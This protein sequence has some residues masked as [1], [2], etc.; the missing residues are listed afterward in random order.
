MKP[1]HRVYKDAYD[2]TVL[3][4]QGGGALGA[5]QAGVFEGLAEAGISPDWVT[6][7]S[8][9]GINAALIAGNAPD[10]RVERLRD[11]WDLVSSGA[12]GNFPRKQ[13]PSQ[14]PLRRVFKRMNATASAAFGVPGFYTP[15]VPPAALMP[16]GNE[17]A[18]SIYDVAPLGSTL[19][20][21]VD[22]DLI[23]RGAIRLSLGA[24]NVET[25]NSTYFDSLNTRIRPEHVLASGALPPAFAPV[26]IDGQCYWDGGIVSNTPLWYVLDNQLP[27]RALIVQVDL[28]SAAGERPLDLDQVMERHKDIMYSS[29]TRFNTTRVRELQQ[30]RTPLHRLLRKLP[31]SLQSDPDVQILEKLCS[32]THID[33]VHFINR[34]RAYS[35]FSKDYEFSRSSMLDRWQAGLEDVRRSVAHPEWLKKLQLA[36]GIRM[37][38]L[39][40]RT[41]RAEAA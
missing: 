24:A 1:T 22:F 18:L 13:D 3:V 41:V 38:D 6:G 29:K 8:I 17:G 5:Y 28:F 33:I 14:D 9:G 40:R 21:F 10:R 19:E 36:D 30:I 15:R 25:G 2:V 26:E 16:A 11:F 37:Y 20:Q 12:F 31:E 7:V 32:E 35:S 34:H 27:G 23:N 39:T 4:L